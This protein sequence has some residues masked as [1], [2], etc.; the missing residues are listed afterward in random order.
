MKK[1][2]VNGVKYDKGKLRWDLLPIQ[3]IEEAVK[4]ITYGANKYCD[5]NWKKVH[6]GIERYYAAALRHLFAWRKG[7]EIDEESNFKHLSHVITNIIFLMYLTEN[8]K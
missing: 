3:P 2:L 7:E 8:N 6:N 1:K 4:V 5:N